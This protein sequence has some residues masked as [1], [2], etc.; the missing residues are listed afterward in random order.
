N[1]NYSYFTLYYLQ[2][3]MLRNLVKSIFRK[4]FIGSAK[5]NVTRRASGCF[6]FGESSR[7]G[8]NLQAKRRIIHGCQSG[9]RLRQIHT[10]E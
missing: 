10:L 1:R 2:D 6:A 3:K 7:R 5:I 4:E 8:E 9:F